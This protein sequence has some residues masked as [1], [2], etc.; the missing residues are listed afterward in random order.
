MALFGFSSYFLAKAKGQ[1]VS[2]FVACF[3]FSRKQFIERMKIPLKGLYIEVSLSSWIL[4]LDFFISEGRNFGWLEKEGSEN[5]CSGDIN[6]LTWFCEVDPL[7]V[8]CSFDL[9]FCTPTSLMYLQLA[10]RK[11]F[12]FLHFHVGVCL[13]FMVHVETSIF[14]VCP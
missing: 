13:A 11:F 10:L 7:L 5:K 12:V 4:V 2:Y 6:M 8:S 3:C 9:F 14:P 1:W